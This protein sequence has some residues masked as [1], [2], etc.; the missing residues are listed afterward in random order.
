MNTKVKEIIDELIKKTDEG[1][2]DWV[3]VTE[4]IGTHGFMDAYKCVLMSGSVIS[5]DI[6]TLH[7][8]PIYERRHSFGIQ[9]LDE[10]GDV[11]YSGCREE[12]KDEYDSLLK[13]LHRAAAENYAGRKGSITE[14]NFGS[15][16]LELVCLPKKPIEKTPT[17]LDIRQFNPCKE[18]LRY[19]ESK[20]SFKEAWLDCENHEWM[21]WIAKKLGVEN[22]KIK[23]AELDAENIDLSSRIEYPKPFQH[24]L[25]PSF[26]LVRACTKGF[27]SKSVRE[28]LTDA[29]FEKVKQLESPS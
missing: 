3:K 26:E 7:F 8:N 25:F 16:Y 28:I 1:L 2:V 13:R 18:G 4:S 6:E 5:T 29:V 11:T 20:A 22:I 15:I 9:I 23:I 10:N 24:T 12:N 27:Q 21:I 19:Y 17:K 14:S